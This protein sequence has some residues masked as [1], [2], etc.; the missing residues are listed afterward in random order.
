MIKRLMSKKA[1]L[2]GKQIPI[3]VIALIALIG[4]ASATAYVVSTLTLNVGIAEAFTVEYAVLGDGGSYVYTSWDQ[5]M[6][7][8]GLA[9]WFTSTTEKIPTGDMKVGEKRFVCVKITNLAEAA[10]PYV[11]STTVTKGGV[12]NETCSA[13]FAKPSITGTVVAKAHSGDAGVAITGDLV[14][15]AV[16]ATPVS[17]CDV[18][19]SVGRGTV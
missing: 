15:P 17:N 14:Q 4:F 13:A 16:D 19:I 2:F 11:I 9:T 6:T 5:A 8:C 12:A 18:T 3:F 10:I 1:N 7:D